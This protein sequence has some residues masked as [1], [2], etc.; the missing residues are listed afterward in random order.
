MYNA[1]DN[2]SSTIRLQCF[3]KAKGSLS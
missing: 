2:D 3:M 1:A